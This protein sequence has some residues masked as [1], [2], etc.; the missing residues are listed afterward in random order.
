MQGR[1]CLMFGHRSDTDL[2][3]NLV[4]PVPKDL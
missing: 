1:I 2:H 4:F 3:K